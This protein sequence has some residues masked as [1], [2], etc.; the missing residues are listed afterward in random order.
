[1]K[2]VSWRYNVVSG[3]T[4]A[5]C[6][7]SKGP[8][9]LKKGMV[10]VLFI[11]SALEV[12]ALSRAQEHDYGLHPICHACDIHEQRGALAFFLLALRSGLLELPV[13]L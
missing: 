11:G 8:C 3:G 10:P 4:A 7:A 2:F 6:D 12:M 9:N 1:M 13:I 5:A